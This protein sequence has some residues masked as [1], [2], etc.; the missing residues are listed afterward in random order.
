MGGPVPISSIPRCVSLKNI[1][2]FDPIQRYSLR[3]HTRPVLLPKV[4]IFPLNFVY[5][6]LQSV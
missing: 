2:S 3:D 4:S 6:L 5:E 1:D